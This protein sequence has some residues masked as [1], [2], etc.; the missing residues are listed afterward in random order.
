MPGAGPAEAA[1]AAAAVQEHGWLAGAEADAA[2]C[3]STVVPVVT[4]HLDPGALD[5]LTEVFLAGHEPAG[6]SSPL[7]EGGPGPS[8]AAS[9]GP[10]LA[11]DLSPPATA[12]G[13]PLSSHTRRRLARALLAMAARTLA[14]PGG[15]AAHLRANLGDGSLASVSLPLDIGAATETIP[16]HLRRAATA[17]HPHCAFPGCEQPASVCDIHHLVPRSQ[18]GPTALPNLVPLCSF[19][20]LTVIHRWGWTLT[21][22][23][24]G[25]TTATSPG[26]ARTLHSHGPPGRAA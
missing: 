5:R 11:A 8:T 19:H 1:W 6:S 16:A 10:S 13:R 22:H 2:G 17:R 4:G 9:P 7:P 23:P 24:D 21:L 20:H 15:L 3:D 26:G 12:S 14:G 18:G 25:G